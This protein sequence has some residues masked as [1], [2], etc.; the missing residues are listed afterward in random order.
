MNRLALASTDIQDFG[1]LTARTVIAGVEAICDPF[2]ALYLPETRLLVVSD[3]HLEKGAAF[4][5]RGMLLPPYDTLA[6][7]K[8]LEAVVLRH[9]PKIVVS[10]GDNFHDRVGSAQLPAIYRHRI[11]SI[12]RGRDWIW[13]NGNHDPEG[14]TDLPGQSA[15]ELCFA[16]LSFRHEPQAGAARGEIA[17][18]LHPSATVKRRE[19]SV[20][21]PC[22][23]TDGR[24]LL[25][26]AFG[27]M[28]GGL[29]L[30]HR[31]MAGLFDR[32]NL[33]AHLL[34]RDR[35][36]SVRFANLMG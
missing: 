18:H 11:E 1:A 17:G 29:D 16:G 35:I 27:V 30:R 2:G 22:F 32:T 34:G 7:L 4:A 21:R 31:A 10:L 25:M 6:T 33:I 26:P 28:T 23:A 12:A 5:R 13:I 24:R 15:D 20:R 3:L 8:I 9:D 36:Y 14:T 19:K